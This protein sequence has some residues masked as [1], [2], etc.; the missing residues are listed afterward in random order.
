MTVTL[1]M[2]VSVFQPSAASFI[3]SGR[4]L[5]RHDFVS[6]FGRRAV[7]GMVH[8]APLPGAPL[9]GGSLDAVLARALQDAESLAAGGGGAVALGKLCAPAVPEKRG[10][11]AAHCAGTPGGAQNAP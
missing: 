5:T 10:R 2:T 9:Y 7:I 3:L 8:L 4:M 6:R 11:P 1:G